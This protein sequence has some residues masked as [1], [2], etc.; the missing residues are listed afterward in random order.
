MLKTIEG[1]YRD[2]KVEITEAPKDV[3]DET[4]VLGDVPRTSH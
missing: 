4:P 1:I 2:G 3:R